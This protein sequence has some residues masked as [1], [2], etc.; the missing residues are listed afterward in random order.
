MTSLTKRIALITGSNTGIGYEVVK[1]LALQYKQNIT[2]IL[3]SRNK[4][5]GIEAIEKLKQNDQLYNID[6]VELDVTKQHSIQQCI[7]YIKQQYKRLD[8]VVCNAGMYYN[9][10]LK[11]QYLV[12]SLYS[13]HY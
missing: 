9:V 1:Q 4:Y 13:I 10:E 5:K 11:I 12:N 2:V 6:Y 8:I 7:T 3:S